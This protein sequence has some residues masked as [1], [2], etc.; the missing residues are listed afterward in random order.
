MYHNHFRCPHGVG[1]GVGRR[2]FEVL[3]GTNFV[4]I[5]DEKIPTNVPMKFRNDLFRCVVFH[6]ASFASSEYI[7]RRVLGYQLLTFFSVLLQLEYGL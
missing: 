4:P 7:L 1:E 2:V 6:L 3:M 5:D